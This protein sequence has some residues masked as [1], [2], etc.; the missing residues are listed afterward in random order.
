MGYI[1]DDIFKAKFYKR[2]PVSPISPSPFNPKNAMMH[3]DI[4]K[5]IRQKS[6][7]LAKALHHYFL[8]FQIEPFAETSAYK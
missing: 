3:Q 8:L 4:G 6:L 2:N 1:L 5:K 7:S